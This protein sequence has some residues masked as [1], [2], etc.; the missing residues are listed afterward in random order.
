MAKMHFDLK[1]YIQEDNSIQII[2]LYQDFK[3]K[4]IVVNF[5]LKKQ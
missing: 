4:V 1:N 5:S 3:R 2:K